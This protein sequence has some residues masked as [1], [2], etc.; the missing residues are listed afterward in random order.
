MKRFNSTKPKFSHLF[1]FVV[2]LANFFHRSKKNLTY[3]MVGEH[4]FDLANHRWEISNYKSKQALTFSLNSSSKLPIILSCLQVGNLHLV[5][6]LM[7][8]C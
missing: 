2:L 3:E 5:F 8:D 1:Q 7:V 4:R 6:V